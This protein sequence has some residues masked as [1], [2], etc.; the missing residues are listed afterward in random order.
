M[1]TPRRCAGTLVTSR[2]SIQ[3]PPESGTSRPAISRSSVVLPEPDGPSTTSSSRDAIVSST[4][5]HGRRPAVV[6]SSSRAGTRYPPSPALG[7]AAPSRCP[8]SPISRLLHNCWRRRGRPSRGESTGAPGINRPCLGLFVES[9]GSDSR[10]AVLGRRGR[11]GRR[12]A[13]F[14]AARAAGI[15]RGRRAQ[16]LGLPARSSGSS[17]AGQAIGLG[18]Q[19]DRPLHPGG[20][21]GDGLASGRRGGSRRPDP[22]G[23]LR[24]DRP[25]ADRP[26]RSRRSSATTGRTPT[27]GSSIACWPAR[28][29]A[30]AGGSTGSTWPTMPIPTASSSTPSG[31]T[32]GDTAT[33]SSGASTPTCPTTASSRSSSPATSS[34]RAIATR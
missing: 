13:G 18:P 3:T 29:T 4:P 9:S 24:P 5:S 19:P 32:P 12:S 7:I 25:A 23:H 11:L 22:P 15:L 10:L 14:A 26:P 34:R 6:R 21:G 20:S 28:I 16:P 31:P 30:S 27:S 33:G 2:P 17:P 1:A 8:C